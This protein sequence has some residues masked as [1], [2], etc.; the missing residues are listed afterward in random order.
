MHA[1]PTP[2]PLWASD[3]PG[4]LGNDPV[5][6]IPTL[7]YYPAPP[8]LAT[9][10]AVVICPGGGYLELMDYEGKDCA[11]WLNERGIAGFVLK[12]RL[13]SHGYHYP[14]IT[15][16]VTRA[17]R[18]VRAHAPEWQLDS[19]RIGVMGGSAGGHL[20]SF[21]LTH[22]DAGNPAHEDPVERAGSRPDFGI[23]SYPLISCTIVPLKNLA[24][25]SP[26][27]ELLRL[28]S[29][30]QQVTSDTAPCFIWHTQDD[31]VVSVRHTL[32]FAEAL[33][34]NGVSYSLH[35]YPSG[36]HGMGLGVKGY[37]PGEGQ[38]LHPWTDEL[39]L[40]LESRGISKTAKP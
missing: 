27:P 22:Y 1:A 25:K 21:A 2:F 20:A 10:A 30:E 34:A 40:W 4:A 5:R 17:M 29:S 11:L 15:N 14:E 31:K 32:L 9:G 36:E 18:Y 8:E 35:I 37:H 16:D 39:A 38:K 24:G 26:T 3:P 7:T 6:D 12:Y 13:A 19:A 33:Q 28:L 23:L